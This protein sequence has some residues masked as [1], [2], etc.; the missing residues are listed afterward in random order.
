MITRTKNFSDSIL[1]S[2]QVCK[3]CGFTVEMHVVISLVCI[4][5]LSVFQVI[6]RTSELSSQSFSLKWIIES[7]MHF[8]QV[9]KAY[10][11][12]I[13]LFSIRFAF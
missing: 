3:T 1:T 13:V 10:Y 9:L 12:Y 8:K 4:Q 7:N 11:A 6:I 5:M 2:C